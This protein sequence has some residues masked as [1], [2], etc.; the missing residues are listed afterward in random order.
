RCESRGDFPQTGPP[1]M[2][3][4]PVSDCFARFYLLH[5]EPSKLPSFFVPALVTPRV[6]LWAARAFCPRFL[7]FELFTNLGE[8]RRPCGIGGGGRRSSPKC[9]DGAVPQ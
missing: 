6:G 5:H 1:A 3:A 8:F 2:A 9:G 4:E 7:S